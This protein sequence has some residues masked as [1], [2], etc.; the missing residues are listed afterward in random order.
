MRHPDPR[1]YP[2][3]WKDQSAQRKVLLDAAVASL[4]EQFARDPTIVAAI[5]FGSYARAEVAPKSDLD[6]IVV[7]ESELG[8]IERTGRFHVNYHVGVPVDWIVYT[9][10]EFERMR[11]TRNFIAQAVAEGKV[12]YARTPA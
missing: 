5:V 6:I 3:W 11:T 12:I 4:R 1:P 8:Q 7:Q 10:E 9:P 2:Q